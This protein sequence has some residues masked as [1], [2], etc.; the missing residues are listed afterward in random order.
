MNWTTAVD[1]DLAAAYQTKAGQRGLVYFADLG[2]LDHFPYLCLNKDE[3]V[4]EDG[5]EKEEILQINQLDEMKA[6]WLFCWDYGMVQTGQSARFKDSDMR[7]TLS[8]A[9]GKAITMSIDT[10][11]T[12]SVGCVPRTFLKRR[13]KFLRVG[14]MGG[15]EKGAWDAPYLALKFLLIIYKLFFSPKGLSLC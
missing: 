8:N 12:A 4:G 11:E 6:V 15:I 1:F 3:G 2:H 13:L 7:L 5:G 10:G 9:A 14:E